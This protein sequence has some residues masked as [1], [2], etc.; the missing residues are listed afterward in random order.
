MLFFIDILPSKSTFYFLNY[1]FYFSIIIVDSSLHC[2]WSSQLANFRTVV[3][4]RLPGAHA[5]QSVLPPFS[6]ASHSLSS[7]SNLS[8]LLPVAQSEHTL[9]LLSF[10]TKC[11]D[12]SVSS[13]M[14]VMIIPI[15]SVGCFD[16]TH[17]SQVDLN[18]KDWCPDWKSWVGRIQPLLGS[19]IL[20]CPPFWARHI[21]GLVGGWR[22][23]FAN[24]QGRELYFP[25]FCLR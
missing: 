10:I 7:G 21:P 23:Q 22:E 16:G 24:W 6:S 13:H 15:S 4:A 9:M 5:T 2:F 25:G 1:H 19:E 14:E 11:P 17:H 3:Q 20:F 18:H 8:D 12:A